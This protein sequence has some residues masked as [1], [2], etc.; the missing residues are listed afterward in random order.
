MPREVHPRKLSAGVKNSGD[1]GILSS[2]NS[3][4]ASDLGAKAKAIVIIAIGI[5]ALA[6]ATGLIKALAS[7]FAKVE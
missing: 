6:I 3:P 4:G 5:N 7:I 1:S 2:V